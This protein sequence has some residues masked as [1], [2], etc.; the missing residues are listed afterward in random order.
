MTEE[1]KGFS[2]VSPEK[3]KKNAARLF[4]LEVIVLIF[5]IVG[6]LGLLYYLGVFKNST[7]FKSSP[8]IDTVKPAEKKLKIESK[9]DSQVDAVLSYSSDVSGYQLELLDKKAFS[10]LLKKWW[11]TGRSFPQLGSN[12]DIKEVTIR[13]TAEKQPKL[14]TT[15][16]GSN[17][18]SSSSIK[19]DDSSLLVLIN[20]SPDGLAAPEPGF[21]FNSQLILTLFNLT[22]VTNYQPSA[23]E[24]KSQNTQIEQASRTKYFDVVKK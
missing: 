21:Y 13:L 20:V 12:S 24:L 7:L 8:Q 18:S 17:I 23:E 4:V 19:M 14:L 2:Y 6:I 3:Q 16:P 5:A 9:N 15:T 1:H 22:H 10:D 11:V